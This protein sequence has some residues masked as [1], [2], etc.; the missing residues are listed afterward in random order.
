MGKY[1]FKSA[2][3]GR[4]PHGASQEEQDHVLRLRF[5]HEENEKT[6]GFY[7]QN[8]ISLTKAINDFRGYVKA[9]EAAVVV[10]TLG[11]IYVAQV[12]ALFLNQTFNIL[13]ESV[14]TQKILTVK[15]PFILDIKAISAPESVS[16]MVN[17]GLYANDPLKR[18]SVVRQALRVAATKRNLDKAFQDFVP[19]KGSFVRQQID[20][21]SLDDA[22]LFDAIKKVRQEYDQQ[23]VIV[24]A[25]MRCEALTAVYSQYGPMSEAEKSVLIDKAQ[26]DE[27]QASKIHSMMRE[28]IAFDIAESM[29]L[30]HFFNE[31]PPFKVWIRVIQHILMFFSD[32]DKS[33]SKDINTRAQEIILEVM[34]NMF[35]LYYRAETSTIDVANTVK[36]ALPEQVCRLA[37]AL[38]VSTNAYLFDSCDVQDKK[39]MLAMI[40]IKRL[41]NML[42]PK[43]LNAEIPRFDQAFQDLMT[44]E[45]EVLIAQVEQLGL[46]E[47]RQKLAGCQ[48]VNKMVAV[49]EE[50]ISQLGVAHALAS[51]AL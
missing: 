47:V 21:V 24:I 29:I 4:L 45:A 32:L 8:S 20:F 42:Q 26:V 31:D 5:Q 36:Y 30:D 25:E 49:L 51:H 37:D 16:A 18:L 1:I 43:I 7:T 2:E 28:K 13:D 3:Y 9:D 50:G 15:A 10:Q 11:E 22:D 14:F 33:V 48:D 38:K 46:C 19:K 17:E 12:E 41:N 39:Q 23:K 6:E 27:M 34:S 40:L 35:L 44:G